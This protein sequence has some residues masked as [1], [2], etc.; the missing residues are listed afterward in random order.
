[1]DDLEP[2]VVQ[3][4]PPGT[5]RHQHYV[6]VWQTANTDVASDDR[7]RSLIGDEIASAASPLLVGASHSPHDA[8]PGAPSGSLGADIVAVF[9]LAISSLGFPISLAVLMFSG[10]LESGMS[11][12][13]GSFVIA[14]GVMAIVVASRSRIVPVATFLQDAPAIALAAATADLIRRDGTEVTDVFV[15]LAVTTLA[16]AA[17]SAL[18]G[19]FRLGQIGR[20]LPT[21]VIGAFVGGTGWLMFKGGLDVMTNTSIDVG[22]LDLMFS[23]G[24]AKFWVPGLILGLVAWLVHRS[25]HLPG[26]ALAAVV[27]GSLGAFYALVA[28]LSSTGSV[29]A[30]GW[31]LGPFPESGGVRLVT[32]GEV[33]SANWSNI[34]TALPGIIGVVGLTCVAQLLNLTS[35]RSELVPRLDIDAELRTGAK[36]NLAASF[37]GVS[38]G[39]QGFGYTLLL[40][41]MGS[42]R[43]AVPIVSGAIL[44]VFGVVGVAAIGYLP[45]F[46]VGAL[47]VMVGLALIDD[48]VNGLRRS[49]SSSERLLGVAI[50]GA[51]AIFGL[52]QGIAAGMVAAG[53]VFI[54]R[55]SRV[56]PV[57]SVHYGRQLRSRV[58]RSPLEVERLQVTGERLAVFE[59]QSFLFFGSLTTLED[60]VRRVTQ[61]ASL[62]ENVIFDFATVTGI[63]SSGHVVV[64]RLLH[65]LHAEG[66]AAWVSGL[67]PSVRTALLATEPE[68]AAKVK[69]FDSLDLALESAEDQQL[70]SMTSEALQQKLTH[71]QTTL[72]AELLA[73]CAAHRFDAGTVVMAQGARCEGLLIVQRG[74]LAEFHVRAD[75]ARTRLRR[76]GEFT[77]VGDLNCLL[78]RAPRTSEVFAEGV[79]D[80]WWLSID[81]YDEL[82]KTK[83]WLIFELHEFIVMIQAERVKALSQAHVRSVQR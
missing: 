58:H 36:A 12:A 77:V 4:R 61:G 55:Y 57:R 20:Y 15:L 2:L 7:G 39:F 44:V 79:V 33:R 70:T 18:L 28:L 29:Q 13:I 45:R 9:T 49:V 62:V 60:N 83:P 5:A 31:L 16:T 76:F 21:S 65:E 56:D 75:G 52:L 10:P 40:H 54:L 3:A 74:R 82:R 68:L 22:S 51:V 47:L 27:V 6:D 72:S 66:I 30:G 81:R 42:T 38:P 23:A 24:M 32:P 14:G 26:Y 43:R 17:A 67:D 11:R 1:M 46:V 59:L 63:D 69:F 78:A 64:A 34:A 37:F 50:V 53:A 19:R 48:W 71:D 8:P 25:P 41:R 73:E 35:I 80:G